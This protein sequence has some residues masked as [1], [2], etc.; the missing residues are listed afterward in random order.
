MI[1]NH[2]A[3]RTGRKEPFQVDKLHEQRLGIRNESVWGKV[4]VAWEAK[5]I[6]LRQD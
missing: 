5:E 3:K 2:A 1:W 4:G 6:P